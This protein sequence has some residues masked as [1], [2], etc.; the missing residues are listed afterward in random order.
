[1]HPTQGMTLDRV[2]VALE[3]VFECGQAYVALSRATAPAGLRILGALHLSSIRA[4]PQVV[5]FYAAIARQNG[6]GGARN[7]AAEW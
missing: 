7:L 3:K 2:E 4:H 1:M 5:A 6:Y